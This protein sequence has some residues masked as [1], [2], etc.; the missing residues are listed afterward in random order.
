MS[1][2]FVR[3]IAPP[4]GLPSLLIGKKGAGKTTIVEDL[5][6]K[7]EANKVPVVFLQPDDLDI[8]TLGGGSVLA[9]IKRATFA[10]LT[11]A[12][13]NKLSQKDVVYAYSKGAVESVQQL[14]KSIGKNVSE[15]DF[16]ARI[17]NYTSRPNEVAASIRTNLWGVEKVAYLIIDDIDQIGAPQGV[18]YPVWLGGLLLGV[19]KLAGEIPNLKC[20]VTLTGEPSSFRLN[21]FGQFDQVDHFQPLV[22]EVK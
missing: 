2:V 17:P 1:D 19:R 13:V 8:L 22:V 7:L 11:L 12:V 6:L 5:S 16:E 9:T 4:Y 10:S 18:D 20:L 21:F 15:I 14:M 3:A